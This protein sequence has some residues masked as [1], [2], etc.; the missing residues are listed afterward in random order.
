[1]GRWEEQ[2]LAPYLFDEFLELVDRKR[3][4]PVGESLGETI[5]AVLS[6]P[7]STEGLAELRRRFLLTGGFPELLIGL[8]QQPIDETS[9]LLESQ[10]T[11]RNDAVERAI[12]KDIPQAHGIENPMVL[13][14]ML[15]TLA[16]QVANLLSP[17]GIC[18]TLGGLAQPTFDRYL[19]YLERAFL[20]FTLQN[21]SGSEAA[22]Q[23]R[24]R[25]LYFV[26]GAI[27]NAA[28]QRGIAPLRDP[29]EMGL[30]LENAVASHLHA[31]SMQTGTRV[32]HWRD[33]SDHE[34]DL[35]YDHPERPLAFEVGNS[36]GHSRG[37]LY[38]L[39]DRY[40]RFRGGCYI[41]APDAIPQTPASARDGVGSL[42][43]DLALL[44]VGA[45]ASWA[46]RQRL[47]NHG[48]PVAPLFTNG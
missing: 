38:A 19:S 25:K 28:L 1:V 13:E 10:R 42:P 43:L 21:Y 3:D 4:V 23:R 2:Y 40:P 20:V 37:G 26:D 6:E 29:G 30:L 17:K 31:L 7:V 45:Q 35:I 33:G 34:V 41:I 36:T 24:G 16:G 46:L 48:E 8:K 44:I 39:Q 18:Q 32:F 14:R 22:R 27:R 11:L 15:Y 9:A 5:R 47:G 12:Y